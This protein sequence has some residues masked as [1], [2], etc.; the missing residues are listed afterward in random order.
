MFPLTKF[1]K[2]G[3]SSGGGA[4]YASALAAISNKTLILEPDLSAGTTGQTLSTVNLNNTGSAGGSYRGT[5]TWSG[6]GGSGINGLNTFRLLSSGQTAGDT[7]NE[8]TGTALIGNSDL[9]FTTWGVYKATMSGS[10]F[11]TTLLGLG[12]GTGWSPVQTGTFDTNIGYDLRT[13]SQTRA[14]TA[15]S[16]TSGVPFVLSVRVDSSGNIRTNFNGT[17]STSYT[18]ISSGTAYENI[19]NRIT[20]NPQVSSDQYYQYGTQVVSS[21]A[22]SDVVQ[23]DF[24]SALKTRWGIT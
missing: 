17:T 20:L 8:P 5:A 10:N 18:S 12:S 15:G 3:V 9:D 19:G 16:Y 4:D 23:D 13:T 24:V 22:V 2:V 1:S 14:G 21:G 6:T 7:S 11:S